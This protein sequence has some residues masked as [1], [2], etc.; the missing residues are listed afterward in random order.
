MEQI[1]PI[2]KPELNSTFQIQ[3][4]VAISSVAQELEKVETIIELKKAK[5]K[6]TKDV[7]EI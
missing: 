4:L 1:N 5:L 6:N 3:I 2:N 7:Q